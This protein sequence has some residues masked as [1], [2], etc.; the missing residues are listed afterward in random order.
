MQ[1]ADYPEHKIACLLAIERQAA[2]AET[3]STKAETCSSDSRVR[4]AI[5][6]LDPARLEELGA[7][8]VPSSSARLDAANGLIMLDEDA[9]AM[10]LLDVKKGT[11]W[12]TV[13]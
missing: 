1:R 5:L 12:G 2:F 4:S 9:R 7:A 8:S 13:S 11:A 6:A 3:V 10:K